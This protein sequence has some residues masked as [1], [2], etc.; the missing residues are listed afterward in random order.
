MAQTNVVTDTPEPLSLVVGH[1]L[2][3]L[4]LLHDAIDQYCRARDLPAQ[5]VGQLQLAL[6]EHVTNIIR[7]GSKSEASQPVTVRVRII[8]DNLVVEV[9]D[10]GPPFNPLELPSPD[11]HLPM[12]K[13]PLGG[14]GIHMMRQLTDRLEYRRDGASNLLTLYKRCR[15]VRPQ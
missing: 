11:L 12:E 6:E 3:D 10:S 14:L 7:H 2:E 15:P 8:D 13:R 5:P 4:R 9:R 1:R